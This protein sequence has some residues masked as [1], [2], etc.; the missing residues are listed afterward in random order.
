[1]AAEGD[2]GRGGDL[3]ELAESVVSDD[4]VRL[5]DEG[6]ER[7]L[8]TAA[9]EG[10]ELADIIGLGGVKLGRETVGKDSRNDHFLDAAEAL[11]DRLPAFR[12]DLQERISLRPAGVQRKRPDLLRIFASEPE[13]DRAAE[14]DAAH[15]RLLDPDRLHEA[16]DIVGE[17][18]GR[19]GPLRLIALARAPRIERDAGEMLGVVG[20]LKRVTGV[21]GG[22]IGDEHQG[23]PAPCWS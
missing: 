13:T 1:V 22:E 10:G 17:E 12:H 9:H 2:L 6:V 11:G 19:I 14:R 23:S 5:A 21:V 20:D 7:L 3:A 16:G 8:R 18:F 15:M 4:R